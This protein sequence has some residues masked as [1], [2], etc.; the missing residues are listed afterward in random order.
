[1]SLRLLYLIFRQVLGLV[2]L[3]ART[4]AAKDVELLVLR[5]EVAILRR[6]NPRPRMN[7]ADRAVFAVLIQ[8]LPRALRCHR[9]V[10][11]NTILRWHRRLVRR[12]WTYPNRTGRPAI[13]DA[14]A[15]LVVRMAREN[16]RWGYVRIQGELVKL[17][18]RVGA[19]T[20]RRILKRRRIPPAPSRHPDT[21]WR[22]FLRIQASSMLAVDFFHVDCALTLRRLYVLFALEVGDRYL[23]VLGVTTHPDGP[24][25][26]QQARNL[27]MDLGDRAARFRF[28]VRDRAGQFAAS[29][30]SVLADAGIEV[31]KIPP[32]CPRANCFAERFVLTVRTEVTDRM[33]IFGEQHLR[34]VLAGYATH[35]NTARP[36]RAMQLR[37]P[38]PTSPVPE[39]VDGRIRRRPILGGLINEYETAA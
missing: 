34:Q 11:P 23:H 25:T 7:W 31:V 17:G 10:T 37:P 4:S 22:H 5:H 24:W 26:T 18:H 1:V 16:P 20:I 8:R 14:I 35:Y 33:L 13:D 19:S 2:L 29:F 6:T 3:L 30:D 36:H 38:R 21:S 15:A 27:V 28:L 39:P 12:R 9:L 32:R